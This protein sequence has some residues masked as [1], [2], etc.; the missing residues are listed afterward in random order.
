M[1][2]QPPDGVEL[3]D[4][5]CPLGCPPADR[6]VVE[7]QDRLHGIPGRYR[8]VECRRC[9]LMRT[10]PRPTQGTIGVY[11]P[12]DYAPYAALPAAAEAMPSRRPRWRRWLI[13]RLGLQSRQL[14][15]I[16]PG[17]LLEVGCASGQWLEG[18]GRQGW[19]VEGI[20]FSEAAARQARARGL[21]VQTAS[22]ETAR[23]PSEPVDV[24]A[25]WMVLEHLHEPIAALR[26][27]RDWTRDDGWL[28][29][30][31]PDAGA[32]PR[33]LFGERAY[34]LHLPNHLYHYTP[35]TMET[36]LR[37]AGWRLE[38]VCWQRNA[39]TLL[40]SFEYL[41]ADRGWKRRL[42]AMR[43]LRTSWAAG[44][45]R[46]LLAWLLGVTRQ[47]GRIEIMAR[48]LAREASRS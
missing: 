44:R 23:P 5:R 31:V 7:G 37:A 48:P 47:S 19:Q 4:R 22:V 32:L 12:D 24:I 34:D 39:N 38:R 30:A 3:E 36:L 13:A 45:L 29:A 26:R 17:R 2:L 40:W 9:G 41:A 11:Y 14:P 27:L 25:A 16:T 8:I 28:L 20:E 10:N 46:M 33:R 35:A 1:N 43:W 18:M 21:A 42:A 15:S 6:L